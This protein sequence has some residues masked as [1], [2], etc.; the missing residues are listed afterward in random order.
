MRWMVT[1]CGGQLGTC[2]V[3]ALGGDPS[4]VLLRAYVHAELDIT[5]A[6]AVEK[7]FDG[8]PD[9]PPDVLVNAAAFTAV[10]RCE[11]ER[12]LA[13]R[14]NGLAPGLLAER[15]RE[16]GV[17]L[18][19]VSTDYVFDGHADRP[20]PE[21]TPIAPRTEY[22]RSKAEGERRVREILPEAQIIRTSWVFGPGW[23][24]V[25]AILRQARMR[26]SGEAEGPLKVVDDQRGCPTYAADLARGIVQLACLASASE[27]AD[28]GGAGS[29]PRTGAQ[30]SGATF[31]GLFHLSN[32]GE[33]TWW[34]FAREILDVTGHADLEIDKLTTPELDLPAERPPYSVLDCGRAARLGVRLRSWQEALRAY[35]E[36]PAGAT[37]SRSADMSLANERT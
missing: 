28:E 10:D 27:S 22:G 12:E 6:G 34:D 5:D 18:V 7:I 8:L 19:H 2:L 4:H 26:R 11:T 25:A 35:L 31:H 30:T 16:A 14:V 37:L 17:G 3:E 15:C 13:H 33:I 24:F 1:G 32:A 21:T 36:S 23:N 9:G 29:R 20:H